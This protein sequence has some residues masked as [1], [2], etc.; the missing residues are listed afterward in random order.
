M[1][2]F[3]WLFGKRQPPKQPEPP[4]QVEFQKLS[5]R[6]TPGN[7]TRAFRSRPVRGNAA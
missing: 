5:F 1:G 3:A 4:R 7:G 6:P 2:L